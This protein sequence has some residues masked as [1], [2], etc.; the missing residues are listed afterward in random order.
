MSYMLPQAEA[1][2]EE[3]FLQER[4]WLLRTEDSE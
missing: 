4:L 1:Q 3:R 2:T